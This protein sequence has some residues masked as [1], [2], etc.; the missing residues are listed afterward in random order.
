M[1][2]LLMRSNSQSKKLILRWPSLPYNT[3]CIKRCD[4]VNDVQFNYQFVDCF[5]NAFLFNFKR[6]VCAMNEQ[7]HVVVAKTAKLNP[8]TLCKPDNS[9]HY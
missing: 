1:F 8:R 3:H 9:L 7:F 5:C 4:N 2:L 6:S